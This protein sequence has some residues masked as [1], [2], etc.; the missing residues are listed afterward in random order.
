MTGISRWA[1]EM[2]FP[3]HFRFTFTPE[4][5]TR[6]CIRLSA[7]CFLV[8]VPITWRLWFNE[9]KFLLVAPIIPGAEDIPDSVN[10]V[11]ILSIM[12]VC[13]VLVVAPRFRKLGFYLPVAFLALVVQD[14][15]RWQPFFYMYT[16]T[17]L[18]LALLPKKFSDEDLN[19]LRFM[20]L[21]I[22]FWAGIYKINTI[23][24]RRVFPWFV[25][26]W[27]TDPQAT[28]LFGILTPFFEAAIG[29]LML[30]PS[31]RKFAVTMASVMLAVVL[32]SLGPIGHNWAP[33]IWPWNV[34][35][36]ALAISLF[37]NYKGTLFDIALLK[38]K[39]SAVAIFLFIALPTLGFWE[40]W[41]NLP[42]FKLYCGCT[43]E[44]EIHFSKRENVAFLPPELRQ[45]VDTENRLPLIR[46]TSTLFQV[47][48]TSAMPLSTM[49]SV[50]TRGLCPYLKYPAET[51]IVFHNPRSAFD[52]K[53]IETALPLCPAPR[54]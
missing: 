5:V 45:F 48:H 43:P 14:E 27:V 51:K 22:Y 47:A 54:K 26:E 33:A 41:G 12:A 52:M 35:I 7:F 24:A 2:T 32:L 11:L 3:S 50:S 19:P 4:A 38:H 40:Y 46:M 30:F 49:H 36:D 34:M 8:T 39:L 18:A 31:T 6:L 44:V 15:L 21:G 13:A 16:F 37:W 28:L 42:S 29:V 25:E 10:L 1:S 17:L 53:Y 9:R 23:F 20:T